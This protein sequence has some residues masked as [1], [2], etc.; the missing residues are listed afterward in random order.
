MPSAIVVGAGVFGASLARRLARDGWETTL[1]EQAQ[2]GHERAASGGESRLIRCSHGTDAWYTRSVR[3]AREL[4]R[5][6]EAETGER[7]LEEAGVAWFARRPRGW[8]ADSEATLRAQGIPVEHLDVGAAQRLFPSL[9]TT[10]LRFVL[11]EPEAGALRAAAATRALA[12][13]AVASG[14]ELVQAVARPDGARVALDDGRTLE[15]DTVVWA[16]G[17][18]LAGLFGEL[19]SLRVT[20]QDY[21]LFDGGPEWAMPPTPGWV[22]YDGA[23]YGVGDLDGEGFKV[24]SDIEGPPSHPD[25]RELVPPPGSEAAAR[26]YLAQRFPALA[27]ARVTKAVT[28]SY[29]LTPDTHFIVDRHPEHA[30]V[31]LLGGGSGHGFKHGPAL[32]E[33]VAAVLGATEA[34][35]PRFALGPRGADRSLRTAGMSPTASRD[36][37]LI[38]AF[39]AAWDAHGFEGALG[40]LSPQVEWHGP[41]EAPEPEAMVGQEA[42]LHAWRTQFGAVFDDFRMSVIE[43]AHGPEGW[44]AGAQLRARSSASGVQIDQPGYVFVRLEDDLIAEVRVFFDRA[45]ARR[46]AGLSP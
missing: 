21:F 18:W 13:S 8:E 17:P 28:C 45:A 5:E 7:L 36:E 40:H 25:S 10:G 27:G 38:R 20:R 24:A 41:P 11:F 44:F 19:V 39:V 16:C 3:R 6:L 4:W 1:V 37:A 9:D 22:D 23:A 43:V 42:A 35:D 14:V 26:A 46:L 15:A 12:T 32:A 31:W 34:P 33:Y 2:P 29:A 30:G